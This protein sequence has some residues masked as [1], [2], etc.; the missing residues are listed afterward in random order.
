[1]S[2]P[3]LAEHM[4]G[5]GGVL[6]GL[7]VNGAVAYIGEGRSLSIL[8]ISDA[9]HP[10]RLARLP[11]V[12][13]PGD[14]AL[15]GDRLY[16]ADGSAGLLIYDVSNPIAPLRLGEFATPASATRVGIQGALAYVVAGD[17]LVI[18]V[19]DST[20]PH[21]LGSFHASAA[22]NNLIISGS[23]VYLAYGS[24]F[25]VSF[26]GVSIVDV[27]N[28][29]TPVALG[30]ITFSDEVALDL[31]VEGNLIY[32]ITTVSSSVPRIQS[33]RL[34][35]ADI[36]NVTN[37]LIQGSLVLSNPN[38]AITR[39]S[40]RIANGMAYIA[41]YPGGLLTLDLHIP[42]APTLVGQST[43]LGG[44][45][46]LQ[47]VGEQLYAITD[48][49]DYSSPGFQIISL[50]TPGS[51]TQIGGYDTFPSIGGV[52]VAN[53]IAHMMH[54]SR[55]FQLID[56]HDPAQPIVRGSYLIGGGPNRIQLV[57]QRAYV[58]GG[59][60]GLNILDTSNLDAPIRLGGIAP[61]GSTL[62]IRVVGNL[63]YIA[64]INQFVIV[65]ISDP[66][67]PVQLGVF[68]HYT[69]VPDVSVDVMG[70]RAYFATGNQG[71]S[72]VDISDPTHPV[73]RGAYTGLA[74]T[75]FIQVIGS[76]AYV[77]AGSDGLVILD[78]S[79]PDSPTL[80][81]QAYGPQNASYVRVVNALAYVAD[82]Y[83]G[84]QIFDVRDPAA[85]TLI[86]KYD[87]G[88]SVTSVAVEGDR[89]Y[90]PAGTAGLEIV[91]LHLDQLAASAQIGPD[92]GVVTTLDSSVNVTIPPGAI[93]RTATLTITP[94]LDPAQLPNASGEI[95]RGVTLGARDSH[96]QSLTHF[97]QPYTL[98]I[99]YTDE[100]IASQRFN[101]AGLHALYWD[102][103]AWVVP[104]LCDTCGVDTALNRVTLMTDQIG[105]FV[106]VSGTAPMITSNLPPIAALVHRPYHHIFIASGSPVPTFHVSLGALPPGL[107]LDANTGVLEG[108][109]SALGTYT[110]T[111]AASNGVA[112]V[113]EQSVTLSVQA[114]TY[115]PLIEGGS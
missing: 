10:T 48:G 18:D 105:A 53:G 6:A 102:G 57:A 103:S 85:P 30:A 80:L 43:T 92:G 67:N 45:A 33:P 78:L 23:R 60:S 5:F 64:M 14:L 106:L 3:P 110:W 63:A 56:V 41:G 2:A 69:G 24:T 95:L 12:D 36:S 39:A 4:G 86:A 35:I 58:V 26:G 77:A 89:V 9:A 40:L 112:P 65:D 20:A 100:Q 81:G 99:S 111:I 54:Y 1:M 52:E 68:G 113:A 79:N 70:S 83:N 82:H 109:P 32:I 75:S 22:I 98:T 38:G 91:R 31:H 93:T 107:Y 46:E 71:L 25:S 115:L 7:A 50:H 29:I 59:N 17:M 11:L 88:G 55:G 16:V 62:D 90:I 19:H 96:G 114:A 21:Q 76:R 72:I 44:S 37:P 73:A 104:P 34:L 49:I 28:P 94:T 8:D 97:G 101:E 51:P 13:F 15:A 42:T 61:N 108:A 66:S 84:V 27:A 74:R 87:T 47:S